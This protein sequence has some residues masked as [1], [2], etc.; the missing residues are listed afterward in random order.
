[1]NLKVFRLGKFRRWWALVIGIIGFGVLTWSMVML[2]RSAS[3]EGRLFPTLLTPLIG[4]TLFTMLLY[5]YTIWMI[6]SFRIEFLETELRVS[7]YGLPFV[8]QIR[9]SYDE[10][11]YIRRPIMKGIIEVVRKQGKPIQVLTSV[12]GG[13]DG[14]V[15][16]FEK[17]IDMDKFQP[18]LRT[19][20]K[21]YSISD[22]INI[23]VM[24]PLLLVAIVFFLP[25]F[26]A[27]FVAWET[28]WSP[29]L[30]PGY[31]F[32]FSVEDGGDIWLAYNRLFGLESK[33]VH[34]S[35]GHDEIWNM[36][37]KTIKYYDL[38]LAD[39][40]GQPWI[41]NYDQM[42]HWKDDSWKVIPMGYTIDSNRPP[43]VIDGKYWVD[44]YSKKTETS[45]IAIVNLET[46]QVEKI[47]LPS[48]L[49]IS[50]YKIRE[51]DEMPD[52]AILAML[53][54]PYH[55]VNFYSLKNNQ[56]QLEAVLEDVVW[57]KPEFGDNIIL[58]LGGFAVDNSGD[59]WVVTEKEEQSR[60]GRYNKET[61][62]W[63]WSNIDK[64]CDLCS[65]YYT[66]MV[67]DNLGRVWIRA[68]YAKRKN[69]DDK[70]AI[71]QGYGLDVF[72]PTWGKTATRIM[73][74]TK[75]NSN[76]QLGF[77]GNRLRL[78]NDGRIWTAD[79]RLVWIDST[80][81]EL[82][83]PLPESLTDLASLDNFP[84]FFIPVAIFAFLGLI[85][86]RFIPN[87]VKPPPPSIS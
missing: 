52:G 33:I 32:G 23:A 34:I 86:V 4:M 72:V 1:M 84:K 49:L 14:L 2:L 81:N 80:K 58:Q 38:V 5:G 77:S 18:F 12:E 69:P 9:C 65:H 47:E 39:S 71:S 36:D 70:Y 57:R 41:I 79:N 30:E 22:K 62:S 35:E 8:S 51:I 55:P 6:W 60:I 26:L 3:F 75:E 11:S 15:D 61:G 7:R 24:V 27:R 25:R 53:G 45:F 66:N 31:M 83:K 19:E 17:H 63:D 73:R 76:Y 68:N 28:E 16:E 59:I 50:G 54:K 56:W 87:K 44:A 46:E 21:R 67:V 85:L 64:D 43:I 42:L 74:Y 40:S 10:I 82:P 29:G 37:A 20:L 13:S 48:D 78:S